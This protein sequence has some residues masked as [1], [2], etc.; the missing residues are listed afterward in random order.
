MDTA[1][2]GLPLPPSTFLC[3]PDEGQMSHIAS[4]DSLN[5]SRTSSDLS[6][7]PVSPTALGIPPTPPAGPESPRSGSEPTAVQRSS[8]DSSKE[9]GV[10]DESIKSPLSNG[11][12][13][14]RFRTGG[15]KVEKTVVPSNNQF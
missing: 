15:F 4:S 8:S 13:T 6:R 9:P 5:G 10:E 12:F 3:L 11:C 7:D 14:T 2:E 1:A